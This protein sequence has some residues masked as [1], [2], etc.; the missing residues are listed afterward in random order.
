MSV[1]GTLSRTIFKDVPATVNAELQASESESQFGLAFPN[2]PQPLTRQSR[3]PKWPFRRFAEWRHF[4]V[5]L[6]LYRQLRSRKHSVSNRPARRVRPSR[7]GE[8][9]HRDCK[10]RAG[11]ERIVA[12]SSSGGRLD[13]VARRSRT[14]RPGKPLDAQR[15][16]TAERPFPHPRQSPGERGRTDRQP[17]QQCS[18]W[19]RH[20][21]AQLQRRSGAAVGLRH[22]SDVRRRA[23]LVSHPAS[24]LH[25]LHDRRGR[26]SERAAARQSG[27]PVA[28][29][30]G[31][32]FHSGRN[33]RHHPHRGRQ[34]RSSS[35]QSPGLQAW[36]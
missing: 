5:A 6:V 30:P 10:C 26:R 20:P 7:P 17:P 21:L 16:R 28:K 14:S 11:R 29:R 1:S 12:E 3:Q 32:R 8:D 22:P 18:C 25:R 33:G 23:Q 2:A 15:D 24:H 19:D 35:G 31:V 34:S 9:R 13:H 36:P 4:A 27:H